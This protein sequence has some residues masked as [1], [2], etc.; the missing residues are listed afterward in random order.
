MNEV[1]LAM[2]QKSSTS[3]FKGTKVYASLYCTKA[4]SRKLGAGG[5]VSDTLASL[6]DYLAQTRDLISAYVV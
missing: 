6:R 4:R 3:F 1:L 2:T 5:I